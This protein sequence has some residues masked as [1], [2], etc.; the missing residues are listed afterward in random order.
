MDVQDDRQ[1][2]L[3]VL[4]PQDAKRNLRAGTV[5][6]GELLNVNQWLAHRVRLHLIKGDPSLFGTKGEQQR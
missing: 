6:N 2:S 3:R 1:R 5:C 4:G